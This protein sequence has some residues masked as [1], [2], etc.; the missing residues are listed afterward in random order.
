MRLSSSTCV[1][2]EE[3]RWRD[4]PIVVAS[5]VGLGRRPSEAWLAAEPL[6]VL[7]GHRQR[8]FEVVSSGLSLVAIEN[9]VVNAG[10]QPRM[11]PT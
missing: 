4:K 6:I 10:K 3:V 9:G 2:V 7:G 1:H 5:A 8:V 11:A